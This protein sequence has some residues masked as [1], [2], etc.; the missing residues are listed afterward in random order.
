MYV[1]RDIPIV[2]IFVFDDEDDDAH[3][4]GEAS[5]HHGCHLK[6]S[7]ARGAK[8]GAAISGRKGGYEG[9]EFILNDAIIAMTP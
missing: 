9:H 3:T 8:G 4:S 1:C 6:F 7:V 2:L 5:A